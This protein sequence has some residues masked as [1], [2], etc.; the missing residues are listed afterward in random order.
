MTPF[1]RRI[2]LLLAGALLWVGAPS[3][4][5]QSAGVAFDL[6]YTSPFS[7]LRPD[8]YPSK[9]LLTYS[10]GTSSVK[11]KV[12]N[13]E[14]DPG[15]IYLSGSVTSATST[16]MTLNNALS[17]SF[18]T[19]KT[20][21]FTLGFAG[22]YV[23]YNGTAPSDMKGMTLQLTAL[24][25]VS[26]T[27]YDLVLAPD[28]LNYSIPIE[29]RTGGYS[30]VTTCATGGVLSLTGK[31]TCTLIWGTAD[32]GVYVLYTSA[33][34]ETGTFAVTERLMIP[35]ITSQTSSVTSPTGGTTTFTVSATGTDPLSYQWRK[36]KAPIS[37]A[38]DARYTLN[39]A[40]K[41]DAGSYD[42]VVS[43][44]YGSTT[45]NPIILSVLDLPSITSQPQPVTV[46]ESTSAIFT[47]SATGDGTLS[48]QWKK[49]GIS[50]PGGTLSSYTLK[51][52]TSVDAGSYSVVV[53]N[54]VGSVTSVPAL[55]SMRLPPQISIQPLGGSVT[56]G[57]SVVLGVAPASA[58]N[59]SYVW[60]KNGVTIQT[61]T[62]SLSLASVG[63]L[64]AGTYTVSVSETRDGVTAT[65]TS[66]AAVLSVLS[67]VSS[68]RINGR[69]L[70]GVLSSGTLL[71][72]TATGTPPF[73]YQWRK[74][75]VAIPG[76][77]LSSLSIAGVTAAG[78]YDVLI[79]NPS[80]SAL[81]DP[82]VIYPP[83]TVIRAPLSTSSQEGSALT[84]SVQAIGAGPL[85]YQWSKDGSLLPGATAPA[86]A[87]ANLSAVDAGS[88]Q[89]QVTNTRGESAL[90]SARVNMVASGTPSSLG[91][92][93]EPLG[94]S[95]IRGANPTI[96]AQV[97]PTPN[98]LYSLWS[99]KNGTLAS[100]VT[101]G[102]VR[103]DGTLILPLS[104]LSE[105]T[106]SYVLQ[107]TQKDSGA[108]LGTSQPFEVT[109]RS[110][111]EGAGTYE[112]LLPAEPG[113]IPD[114]ALFR[115]RLT[116]TITSTGHLSGQLLYNEA[117]PISGTASLRKYAPVS[118]SF[119]GS[120]IPT[121]DNPL[122]A[123]FTQNLSTEELSLEMDFSTQPP[124]L[125][126][127]VRDRS[128]VSSGSVLASQIEHWTRSSAQT[129]F[130]M[131]P[132]LSNLPG[133]YS[134]LSDPA[135][136]NAHS[137]LQLQVTSLG[138][139]FWSS[140]S[141]GYPSRGYSA[142][143]SAWLNG[144][145][146]LYPTA[147]LYSVQ[148]ASTASLFSTSSLLARAKFQTETN[149]FW[150]VALESG[151]LEWQ[152]TRLP[153]SDLNKGTLPASVNVVGGSL[154]SKVERLSFP[155]QKGTRWSSPAPDAS[156]PPYPPGVS[157]RLTLKDALP[158]YFVTISS[159]GQITSSPGAQIG[160]DGTS[161][162]LDFRLNRVTGA[163]SGNWT[164][165]DLSGKHTL[166]LL[167]VGQRASGGSF[168]YAR[169][170]AQEPNGTI[171]LWTLDLP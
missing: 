57:A 63:T 68:A 108:L 113:A 30:Y 128:S 122:K 134:L 54:N 11:F 168:T 100:R 140:R 165:A 6:T 133:C 97:T 135:A 43:N 18:G 32:T 58:G 152:T 60:K 55:L 26:R 158:F 31:G 106:A 101:S 87:I 69:P 93:V 90:A 141:A 42:V 98:T 148:S 74:Q 169:G 62:A 52:A 89:V 35:K 139:V 71:T 7:D 59:Y 154:W 24:S 16:G 111:D 164:F 162:T 167:G 126:A 138:R 129:R 40:Q 96:S 36:N 46:V 116:L 51:S 33:G 44:P 104:P 86:Y 94:T 21:N 166:T 79:T 81:S 163:L 146:P 143:G 156:P 137:L 157:L 41:I 117:P 15:G 150:G 25:S 77:T 50:I 64:D 82:V 78:T 102:S 170:W 131:P 1:L 109:L 119:S 92:M 84:L 149:G 8:A 45:S 37:S 83:L 34:V 61:G 65:T 147:E 56:I 127:T 5:A 53:S 153:I 88:Y 132:P 67:P 171:R 123:T 112:A 13:R 2:L 107:M 95:V 9:R 144:A 39:S 125:K 38:T 121:R 29:S 99:L 91:W 28:L 145:N 80:G 110:W 27:P 47:V 114:T 136:N 76:G 23:K 66:T 161:M 22:T 3:A 120:F 160:F 10:D 103:A 14:G 151:T 72:A 85:A 75:G 49:G 17:F 155:E 105:S 115:G 4:Q 70:D 142:S 130:T 12:V 118:R 20:G 19:A 73:S 48:Y 124:S 159:T